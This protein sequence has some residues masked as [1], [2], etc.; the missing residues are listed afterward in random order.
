[1]EDD[2]ES[3]LDEQGRTV[4]WQRIFESEEPNFQ[5]RCRGHGERILSDIEAVETLQQLNEDLYDRL[6]ARRRAISNWKRLKIVIVILK[7]T[8]GRIDESVV[9]KKKELP[10]V[11]QHTCD[12]WFSKYVISPFSKRLIAW[13]IFMTFLYLLA[14]IMDTLIIGFH[15]RVLKIP[16]INVW[17]SIFS[18]IMIIDIFLKF[19]VAQ[20]SL[21]SD[22]TDQDTDDEEENEAFRRASAKVTQDLVDK[23]EEEEGAGLTKKQRQQLEMNRRSAEIGARKEARRQN[24]RKKEIE[25]RNAVWY[26]PILEKR[27]SV[28]ARKYASYF[29]FDCLA[30]IPVLVYELSQGLVTNEADK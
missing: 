22:Q 1:M 9:T 4:R 5:K 13:N 16:E 11:K 30:C 10:V 26:D 6:E 3:I 8:G 12:E 17:Q 21:V 14:I 29:F 15:L 23:E 18:F 24:R 19:F 20:R 2:T 7:M 25:R 27:L 28:I